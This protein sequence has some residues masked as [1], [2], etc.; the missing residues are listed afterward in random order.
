PAPP[1]ASGLFSRLI[2]KLRGIVRV[3]ASSSQSIHSRGHAG[4]SGRLLRSGVGSKPGRRSARSA[5]L[6]LPGLR[7]ISAGAHVGNAVWVGSDRLQ[8]WARAGYG[9]EAGVVFAGGSLVDCEG[10]SACLLFCIFER[11]LIFWM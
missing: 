7:R 4:D 2:S 9:G 10:G 6:R 5:G 3:V 1:A 8:M 11:L